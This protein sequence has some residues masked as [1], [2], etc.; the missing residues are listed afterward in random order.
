[1]FIKF[2]KY[3]NLYTYRKFSSSK[4]IITNKSTELLR[5]AKSLLQQGL[6]HGESIEANQMLNKSVAL[7]EKHGHP[8]PIHLRKAHNALGILHLSNDRLPEAQKHLD[9]ALKLSEIDSVNGYGHDSYVDIAGVL[10]DLSLVMHRSGNPT[11]AEQQLKRA[12]YMAKRAYQP[13]QRLL[14]ATYVNLGDLYCQ[15]GKLDEAEKHVR[16]AATWLSKQPKS[17]EKDYLIQVSSVHSTLGRI[18]LL[19]GLKQEARHVLEYATKQSQKLEMDMHPV[20]GKCIANLALFHLFNH[21]S[22]TALMLL[23]KARRIF[24]KSHNLDLIYCLNNLAAVDDL[25]KASKFYKRCNDILTKKCNSEN[26]HIY[27]CQQAI[28]INQ[29]LY[30]NVCNEANNS[31]IPFPPVNLIESIKIGYASS[32]SNRSGD[33]S[34]RI[35]LFSHSQTIA[36]VAI[37]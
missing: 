36:G 1:M 30:K 17:V 25:D 11:G 10:N 21:N 28:I 13:D 4:R 27:Q 8:V 12:L 20:Y 22:I 14:T 5:E 23:N 3:F 34:P 31:S 7:F 9:D 19:K 6:K 24:S 15:I 37:V 18:C 29:E 32:I 33:K 2:N 16:I 35:Q 26:S